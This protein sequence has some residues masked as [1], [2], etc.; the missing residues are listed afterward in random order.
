MVT[1]VDR[2]TLH[3]RAGKGG[4]GCVSVRREKFKPLAGPDG[5]NGGDG[6]DIVLVADPQVTTLLSYH[7]SP[8]RAAGNGGFGMGDNRSGAEGEDIE[9]AVPVGT[10]VKDAEGEFL[11][12][13]L[14]PGMR[15]VVAPGG[16]GGLGNAA[17]ATTKRKAPGFALL[18]TPGWDGDV[19]LELK[20]VA[21][22]ALVGFPSA[23][24]SSLIAA[25]SAARPKIADYP[26][27]TLH[28]NLGVVQAGDVRFTVADVPGLIEGAS[29]GRGLGLEF[30]R[31]VERCTA[32][33]HVLDCATLEPG[34]DPLTDLDVILGE[35]AAYPVP[36][37]QVPLLDRPQ[38]IALNK[39]D[40]PEAKDLADLV[41]PELEARGYRVFE[42]STVSHEGLRQLSFALGDIVARHRADEASKP[43]PPRVVIR[44]K[45][46]DHDFTVRVEGGTYG[47]VYRILGEKPVRWVQQTDFQNDEA[48]GFLAD[49]LEK[50]GVED[51]LYRAGATPGATVVIGE[52]DG[53]VFDWQPALT[54]AA[55]LMTAPR[56][57]DP[58]LD[59][60]SR[61]TTSQ[62]RERYHDLMDAKAAA[63]AELEAER[64]MTT[65]ELEEDE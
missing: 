13:M 45:G 64:L 53:I 46:A 56:G 31:H 6:G 49:R 34:R 9:L 58:R 62:R 36:E 63:R 1:F 47:P 37:G 39:V 27:T 7:H 43:T 54:S 12:D 5:G 2:V 14:D 18:G 52:G 48:V 24:K 25:V 61:R 38:L 33:V 60:N 32:L 44:P 30:L 15:F 3:L 26:F 55:E 57:T 19:V 4:N 51:E 35:L 50:L 11:A 59:Q 16:R 28:P 41:R 8:H 21:D 22:V 65:A 10:V 17:L 20:T 29:E 42:I 40:V 23:G